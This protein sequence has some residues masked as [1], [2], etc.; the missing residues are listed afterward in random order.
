MKK[1]LFISYYWP[2]S[3]GPGVQRAV[4]FVRYLPEYDV[5][6]VVLT[7]DP[8]WASYPF[9][10]H[11]LAKEV[12]GAVR[13]VR[14]RTSEP[15]GLVPASIRGKRVAKPGFAGDGKPGMF[16]KMMRYVRGNW[17]IPDARRGWN[18]HA[19]KAARQLLAG[20][21]F[22]AILTT[23][24]PH[25]TQLIG[26]ALQQEFNLPWIADL[27]DP[28]TDIYYN[29]ALYQG[30]TARRKN[31]ALERMVLEKAD[32]V[33]T[34]SDSLK[35][36]L[37]SKSGLINPN[38]IQVIPNGFDP[39]DFASLP[40]PAEA[41]RE[42]DNLFRIA[43]TGTMSEAYPVDGFLL[44]LR[45]FQRCHPEA[46]LS[47]R[48]TGQV[49]NDILQRFKASGIAGHLTFDGYADHG[50]ALQNMLASDV[51]LLII[52]DVPHNA[53]ILTGKLFE[54][55][56]SRRPVLG[57]GPVDGDAAGIIRR[58]QIGRMFG[59][60]DIEAAAKWLSSLFRQKKAGSI[61]SAGNE[62][63]GQYSRK[64]QARQLSELIDAASS[65]EDI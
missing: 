37:A 9:I 17:L 38:K 46:E 45:Q 27:R 61:L 41:P 35:A 32:A 19:L 29:R 21:G 57:F 36:L 26:M 16:T 59:Y 33:V 31:A 20:D 60:E 62:H 8:A 39:G 55:M 64:V 58:C 43:Y 56:G 7:V 53:G 52:P 3:G 18:G 49:S 28:W 12:P 47:I 63:A 5:E 10:D 6:P 30:K 65:H 15:W 42:G 54:Y 23:S 50:R 11:S 44:A 40:K 13:V 14:T 24:P 25:S 22:S 51:L 4:K 1:L 34:V 2:P 48:F